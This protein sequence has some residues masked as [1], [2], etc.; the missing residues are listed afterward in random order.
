MGHVGQYILVQRAGVGDPHSVPRSSSAPPSQHQVSV[1]NTGQASQQL[2]SV[3]ARGRPASADVEHANLPGSSNDFVVQCPNPGTQAVT[4]RSRIQQAVVYGDVS[5]DSQLQNYTIIGSGGGGA[6]VS[7]GSGGNNGGDSVMMEHPAAAMQ[8]QTQTIV[9]QQQQQ[10][11]PSQQQQQQQQFQKS[12]LAVVS[13]TTTTVSNDTCSCS[14]KAMIVCKKCG[15]FCHDNCIGPS[16][17]CRTCF[18]R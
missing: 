5:V 12:R 1:I 8:S 16:K 7:A 13:G 17:L 14:L 11:Q 2:V 18:I 10:Q 9:Q 4:R 3:G 15:A 6:S